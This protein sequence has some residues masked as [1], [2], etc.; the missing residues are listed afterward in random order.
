MSMRGNI[1]ELKEEINRFKEAIIKSIYAWMTDTKGGE[2]QMHGAYAGDPLP[3]A[4]ELAIAELEHQYEMWEGYPTRQRQIRLK[5]ERLRRHASL[6]SK[7]PKALVDIAIEPQE[8][9]MQEVIPPMTDD[10]EE[11]W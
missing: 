9:K 2:K 8:D 6:F 11:R 4:L 5:I 1:D 10:F 3:P 7:Y